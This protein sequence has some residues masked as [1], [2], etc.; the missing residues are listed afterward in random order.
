MI[1]LF[2]MGGPL[3]MS[4][5]TLELFALLIA[6]W[7]APA[8]VKEIGLLALITGIIGQLIGLYSAFVTVEQVGDVSIAVLMGGLK[9]SS[10][11]TIYGAFIYLVSLLIRIFQKPKFW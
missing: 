2:N 3:F 9:I 6:L 10:I 4:V 11:T 1:E 5:L 8:W 7:K